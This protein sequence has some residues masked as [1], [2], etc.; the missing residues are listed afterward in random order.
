MGTKLTR[1]RRA[2]RDFARRRPLLYRLVRLIKYGPLRGLSDQRARRG[3]LSEAGE[4]RMLYLGSGGRRQPRMINLDITPTTA[5][6]VVGDGY[7]L[8]FADASFDA[9]FCEYVIEHVAD[10]EAF[11]RAASR[12]L[13]PS[14]AWYLEVPF[15]QPV[16]VPGAD[17]QR[18]TLDG[19][20]AAAERAGLR[21]VDAGVHYGP[22][23]TLFWVARDALALLVSFGSRR[24]ARV[25]RYVLAWALS[26]LLLL[27]LVILRHKLGEE[28][29]CGYY[30][31][32]RP[33]LDPASAV[34]DSKSL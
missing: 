8:P 32:A 13:K 34:D 7:R 18:W 3:L 31:V 20:C 26:P 19:F 33:G 23:F 16:H 4:G 29:A 2:L 5:P 6:D 22:G 14:G 25:A 1:A 10:P 9:I 24:A 11:L 12:I 15:L 28:C 21:V 27:D 17:F 30:V